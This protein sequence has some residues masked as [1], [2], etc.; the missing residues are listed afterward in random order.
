MMKIINC[1]FDEALDYTS[2]E[3]YDLII[4]FTEPEG[5]AFLEGAEVF[6]F[7]DTS[8]GERGPKADHMLL[9]EEIYNKFTM[10][11]SSKVL[12]HCFAGVSR[13]SAATLMF[14][15][16]KNIVETPIECVRL[17]F[18]DINP[19]ATPNKWMTHWISERFECPEI[20]NE[21]EY[22]KNTRFTRNLKHPM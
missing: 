20:L 9:L 8:H 6:F 22:Q 5:N 16:Q 3:T 13:S 2:R 17:L 14:L 7:K 10:N 12:I 4:S 11:S 21:I 1:S 18:N 15:I 19:G